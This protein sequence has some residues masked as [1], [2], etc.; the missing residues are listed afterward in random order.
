MKPPYKYTKTTILLEAHKNSTTKLQKKKTY[1]AV[2]Y[3]YL[4]KRGTT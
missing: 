2:L 3:G 4:L 1:L